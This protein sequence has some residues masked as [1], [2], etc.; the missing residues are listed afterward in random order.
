M[1]E[2]IILGLAVASILFAPLYYFEVCEVE[3]YQ[4]KGAYIK[5]NFKFSN[6]QT[7]EYRIE[8]IEGKNMTVL[9]YVHYKNNTWKNKT[10]TDSVSNPNYFP[11]VPM[12]NIGKKT[13]KFHNL[14]FYL[15]SDRLLNI[16]NTTYHTL[17]Y[18][19]GTPIGAITIFVDRATGII[20]NAS[21]YISTPSPGYTFLAEIKD[22]N[23]KEKS[24]IPLFID[25]ASFF[26][27]IGAFVYIYKKERKKPPL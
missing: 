22:T 6:I 23:I 11:A 26:A 1:L 13:L 5:Y 21:Q 20:V 8:K 7:E 4:F 2:K 18:V 16:R 9:M 17:E 24:C 15:Q 10:Y 27:F 25:V 3:T 14:T 19:S 12:K